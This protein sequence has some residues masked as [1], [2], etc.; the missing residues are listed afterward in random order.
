MQGPQ[1]NL[2]LRRPTMD[3][4]FN[5]P[6]PN[7]VRL[8]DRGW[9]KNVVHFVTKHNS[10]GLLDAATNHIMSHM[11][12]GSCL[13]DFN[14]LK[15][16]YDTLRKL[17][18]IN[19]IKYHGMPHV[20]DRVR[21]VQ[22]YTVCHGYPKK[23]KSPKPKEPEDSRTS[24][25]YLRAGGSN[26]SE[27]SSPSI[28]IENY[29]SM[30]APKRTSKLAKIPKEDTLTE[31]RSSEAVGDNASVLSQQL[32]SDVFHTPETSRP[33]SVAAGDTDDP[34]DADP[35]GVL[36][37][38]PVLQK[39]TED[40]ASEST[41]ELANTSQSGKS[42]ELQHEGSSVDIEWALEEFE[43]S[44]PPLPE[45]PSEPEWV[46]NYDESN[47][48]VRKYAE[49]E[50]KRREKDF[51]KAKKS[52]H[53][54]EK[55]RT[56]AIKK[57]RGKLEAQ[58][59]ESKGKAKKAAKDATAVQQDS[60]EKL[61]FDRDE[62]AAAQMAFV[63][64]S[65]ALADHATS[66]GHEKDER[67]G[68]MQILEPLPITEDEIRAYNPTRR[69]SLKKA[70]EDALVGA[71]R[72]LS[73]DYS[74][75]RK[76][77]DEISKPTRTAPPVPNNSHQAHNSTMDKGKGKEGA[78]HLTGHSLSA[79]S[80]SSTLQAVNSND[81]TARSPLTE[82]KSENLKDPAHS[83][84]PE[85]P[86]KPPKNRK[87]CNTPSKVDGKVDS[88]WISIFMKDVDEVA[89]HTGLFFPGPH[90]DKLLGDVED[91]IVDWVQHDATRRL[92]NG[93]A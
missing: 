51:E 48:E 61:V 79:Q 31:Q 68:S 34:P 30:K 45:V 24:H 89:A 54:A 41:A 28:S 9:W 84:K 66:V 69:E 56:K 6:F 82:V 27:P 65:V 49:K 90:Y 53:A 21:F 70:G 50:N 22:Y 7:D 42:Q 26:S 91:M 75:T 43:R 62:A 14:G 81:S 76:E 86:S 83:S 67:R 2:D 40:N 29:D 60:H 78:E 92:I 8:K 59:K 25:D 47:K 74:D 80:L 58:H 13:M 4:N 85:K 20:P 55:A 72:Q 35:P 17:E 15:L 23:P 93:E 37:A 3:P 63:E 10:E 71:L 57:M 88:K 1:H 39:P 18:D 36:S 46:T 52:W 87:F 38:I 32:G 64:N 33:G 11:E 5:Q 77:T 16:R 19:D 44:L 12:F 73:T